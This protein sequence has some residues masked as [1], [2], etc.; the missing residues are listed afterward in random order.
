MGEQNRLMYLFHV[1]QQ[2]KTPGPHPSI[3]T[4]NNEHKHESNDNA[5]LIWPVP[6]KRSIEYN[7]SS[8]P[9]SMEADYTPCLQKDF[10]NEVRWNPPPY[11]DE[12]EDE[13]D[14]DDDRSAQQ[15]HSQPHPSSCY[16]HH[17]ADDKHILFQH[18]AK[19]LQYTGK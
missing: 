6:R 12:D 11:E 8:C 17:Y 14:D 1:Y 3:A 5:H 19:I 2:T 13:E 15:P 4:R 7:S 9:N 16:V 18:A 10:G